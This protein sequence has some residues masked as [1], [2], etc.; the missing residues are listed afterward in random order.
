RNLLTITYRLHR[1][2]MSESTISIPAS[3][4]E[5]LSL[6]FD[7]SAMSRVSAARW[8]VPMSALV[9]SSV[10]L[11]DGHRWD[12]STL[13]NYVS[14]AEERAASVS[15]GNWKRRVAFVALAASG[16]ILL[17][18]SSRRPVISDLLGLAI[19]G[20]V[21]WSFVS[22]GWADDRSLVFKRLIVFAFCLLGALGLAGAMRLDDL[23][24]T[25]V[26]VCAIYAGLGLLAELSL[27]TFRPWSGGYRFAGTLHPNGQAL[28]CGAM[29]IAAFLLRRT[30]RHRW[31][32][33]GLLAL[34]LVCMMLTKSRTATGGTLLALGLLWMLRRP[35]QSR[36]LASLA[37]AWLVVAGCFA[38]LLLNTGDGFS[39]AVNMGRESETAAGNGRYPIW[40]TCL[41]MAGR[42]LPL[43]V[44]FECFW[45]PK[46]IEL[47]S[48][49]VGWPLSSA[50]SAYLEVL[51]SLGAIGLLLYLV[52]LGAGLRNSF[53]RHRATNEIG[54]GF[55]FGL[56]LLGCIQALME[57]GF[58]SPTGFVPFMAGCGLARI[59]Y[60]EPTCFTVGDA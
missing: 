38:G 23:C 50:H 40:S 49:K 47:V 58:S 12:C 31:L 1:S 11:V 8:M 59:A 46:R 55:L 33:T 19:A 36:V 28:N 2:Q 51:L 9:L 22:L 30:D 32:Y 27:G 15:S 14:S 41:E 35:L 17:L 10:F 34:A 18:T 45:L 20:A 53:V 5:R 6:S 4:T 52:M 43:G 48:W 24:K 26:W 3:F 44:G 54:A 7:D 21:V 57:S 42:Q 60:F 37:V 25:T 16:A 39:G 56:L 29:S 13:T